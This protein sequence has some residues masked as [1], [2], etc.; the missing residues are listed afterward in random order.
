MYFHFRFFSSCFFHHSLICTNRTNLWFTATSYFRGTDLRMLMTALYFYPKNLPGV[1]LNTV[2]R[3]V[4]FSLLLKARLHR[5]DCNWSCSSGQGRGPRPTSPS[6][7][8][9]WRWKPSGFEEAQEALWEHTDNSS[10][11]NGKASCVWLAM[12]MVRRMMKAVMVTLP[13][14][15]KAGWKQQDDDV[16]EV[17]LEFSITSHSNYFS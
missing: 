16:N 10:E 7:R 2:K 1:T 11:V 3:A 13:H 6:A 4:S 8:R 15:T 12:M 5:Q 9:W 14:V 17:G